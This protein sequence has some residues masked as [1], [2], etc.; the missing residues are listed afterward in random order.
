[1]LS[2][3][4]NVDCSKC[5]MSVEP[6]DVKKTRNGMVCSTCIME[7]KLETK[8]AVINAAGQ[9]DVAFQKS[10]NATVTYRAGILG[11]IVNI[12]MALFKR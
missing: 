6:S 2:Q 4:A 8:D 12:I 5:G 9:S 3:E 11:N 10:S 1:M 7:Q